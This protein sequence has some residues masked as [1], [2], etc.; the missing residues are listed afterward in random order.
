MGWIKVVGIGPGDARDMTKRAVVALQEC[1]TVIGYI[2]YLKLIKPMVEGKETASSG[3]RQEVDRCQKALELAKEGKKVCVVSSGDPGIYGMAGLLLE[4]SEKEG[5]KFDVEI[6]PGVSAI[7]SAAGLLGAPLMHDFA[8]IS[9]SDHLTC[10]EVIEQRLDRA[11]EADFV[12]ALY[13]PKSRE[14]KEHLGRALQIIAKHK[15]LSTPVGIVKNASREGESVI[16]TTLMDVEKYDIDM[17]TIVIIGNKNTFT[18]KGK[19][20]TP[21]GYAL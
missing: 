13:N 12:I 3:M 5:T 2:T 4:L 21:R 11:S 14:R 10:W 17:T 6:I 19:M 20:I 15:E 7:N 8:V 18:K 16:I 9:L 1:D